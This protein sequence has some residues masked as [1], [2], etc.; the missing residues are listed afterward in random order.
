ME[1]SAKAGHNV[2]SLFKKIA[3]SLP[4]MEKDIQGDAAQS[5]C[6]QMWNCLVINWRLE[7]IRDRCHNPCA[8]GG[9]GSITMQLLIRVRLLPQSPTLPSPSWLQHAF[10]MFYVFR[11]FRFFFMGSGLLRLAHANQ[12]LEGLASTI[13]ETTLHFPTA[14]E[15]RAVLGQP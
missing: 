13:K 11:Q 8:G 3:M 14:T 5:T 7:Y 6:L 4:G 12:F 10:S 9:T 1:T 2:K 15:V